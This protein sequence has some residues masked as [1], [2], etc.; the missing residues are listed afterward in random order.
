MEYDGEQGSNLFKVGICS[1]NGNQTMSLLS[2]CLLQ[3]IDKT[4]IKSK[5]AWCPSEKR[6]ES[7]G[8]LD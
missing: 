5:C 2:G 1:H 6:W 8:M 7:W 3:C 4:V